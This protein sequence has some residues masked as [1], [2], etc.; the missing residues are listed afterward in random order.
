MGLQ[1]NSSGSALGK[2]PVAAP[3]GLKKE[4]DFTNNQT[5]FRD[6]KLFKTEDLDQEKK[7]YKELEEKYETLKSKHEE[8]EKQLKSLQENQTEALKEKEKTF[9]EQL[10]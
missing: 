4:D 1:R 6:Q 10:E 3:Q 9:Q 7:K 2:P 8:T 5:T